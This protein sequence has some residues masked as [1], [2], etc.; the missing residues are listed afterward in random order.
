MDNQN[1]NTESNG[2]ETTNPGNGNNNGNGNG[3]NSQCSRGLQ[4]GYSP[5]QIKIPM[6]HPVEILV[7]PD[8]VPVTR[9]LPDP[10]ICK[11]IIMKKAS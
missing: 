8:P 2:N 3:N 1:E 4:Q 11:T 10:C 9:S 5:I 6:S 7:H